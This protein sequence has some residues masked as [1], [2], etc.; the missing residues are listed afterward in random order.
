MCFSPHVLR[1]RVFLPHAQ[2]TSLSLN[3]S[4]PITHLPYR[5]TRPR[6]PREIAPFPA[7]SS[8]RPAPAAS[9]G[10]WLAAG[11]ASSL[12]TGPKP[13]FSL[14]RLE[15]LRSCTCRR[16]LRC[17][18]RPPGRT[19]ASAP[20]QSC[21]PSGR[22]ES[23][24]AHRTHRRRAHLPGLALEEERG[25]G[26]GTDGCAQKGRAPRDLQ[27]PGL[28]RGSRARTAWPFQPCSGS[29]S[30]EPSFFPSLSLKASRTAA[31]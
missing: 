6:R 22:R 28:A 5:R 24:E 31:P 29:P 14:P 23:P 13:A 16:P 4:K 18:A 10:I 9:L 1:R 30:R 25:H 7:A 11:V 3:P 20:L 21:A 12:G 15:G 8:S 17:P 2:A 26:E 27:P 19:A